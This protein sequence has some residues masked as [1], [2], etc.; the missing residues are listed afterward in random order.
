MGRAKAK[1]QGTHVDM[2]PLV[3]ITFLLLTF[4]I[5]TAKFKSDAS[6]EQKFVIKRPTTSLDTLEVP[7]NN[8]SIISIAVDTVLA[9]T[10]YFLEVANYEQRVDIY[11]RCITDETVEAPNDLFFH[12]GSPENPKPLLELGDDVEL[13]EAVIRNAKL[14]NSEMQ[15]AIDADHRLDFQWVWNAMDKLRINFST[16]FRYITD[17]PSGS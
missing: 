12:G 9:D 8:V 16:K 3:D 4:F 17:K 1:R 13:L 6:S 2:T 11:N 15:F 7:K 5:M 14:A 10:N